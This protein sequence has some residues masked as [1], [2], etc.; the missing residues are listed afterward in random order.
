MNKKYNSFFCIMIF[1]A[2]IT[3]ITTLLAPI[4]VNVWSDNLEI[5][6]REKIFIILAVLILSLI[7]KTVTIL[8]REHFAKNFNIGNFKMMVSKYF[9]LDYDIIVEKGPTN[10]IER[11]IMAT[12]SIY[13]YMTGDNINIWSS[14]LII[15]FSLFLVGIKNLNIFLIML[16]AIPINYLGFKSINKI[17]EEKSKNMQ[18]ATSS[19]WQKIMSITK[20]T[21]YLKQFDDH[22]LII[23]NMEPTLNHIYKSMADINIFAQS[24]SNFIFSLNEIFKIAIMIL[25]IVSFSKNISSYGDLILITLVVPIYFQNIST[26]TNSN[27]NKEI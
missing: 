4:L 25:T 10:L 20:H 6:N 17:L 23:D 27:L 5:L 15:T 9:K 11:M 8:I 24:S 1:L 21:D 13:I 7:I 26:I 14:S 12:N 22:N 18:I 19:G 16:L 2:T 3:S